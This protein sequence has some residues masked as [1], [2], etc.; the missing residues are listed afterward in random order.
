MQ[1]S[2]SQEANSCSATHEIPHHIQNLHVYHIHNSWPVDNNIFITSLFNFH[3][4]TLFPSMP[5]TSIWA[6]HIN[7]S[8]P[9][10]RLGHRSNRPSIISIFGFQVTGVKMV[11]HSQFTAITKKRILCHPLPIAIQPA[12]QYCVILS[13]LPF[14]QC[15]NTVSSL[16]ITIQPTLENHVIPSQLP[17]NQHWNTV[18]FPPNYHLTSTGILCHHV[19]ITI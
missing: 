12:L 3:F 6:S 16:P 17:F 11:K 19:P 10:P 5:R 14:S 9:K 2:Y 7:I 15:W 8:I 18:S 4:I 1:H 13:Q